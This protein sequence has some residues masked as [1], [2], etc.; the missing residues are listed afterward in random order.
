MATSSSQPEN[1]V[2]GM[3]MP[4]MPCRPARSASH[5]SKGVTEIRSGE[6]VSMEGDGSRDACE[7]MVIEEA[8][9]DA[10]KEGEADGRPSSVRRVRIAEK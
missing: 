10:L 2:F 7:V 9:E 5:R 3:V 4:S 8:T 1:R 6:K